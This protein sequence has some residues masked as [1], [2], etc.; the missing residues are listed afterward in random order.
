MAEEDTRLYL[1]E[2]LESAFGGPVYYRPPGNMIFKRPC[3]IY[4]KKRT[5][6]SFANN[7]FYVLGQT[8]QVMVLSDMPGM[9]DLMDMFKDMPGI[10]VRQNSSY[11]TA[12]VV[13][14]VFT[15]SVNTI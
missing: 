3:V 9:S 4:D 13:H 5:D 6:T 2:H 15:V 12:D 8:Y 14:D 1:H 10:S 11:V 7:T